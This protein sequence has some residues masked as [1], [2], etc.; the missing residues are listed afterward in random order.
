MGSVNTRLKKLNIENFE[1][2]SK[3][4]K[5]VAVDIETTGLDVS[6]DNIIE[7]SALKFENGEMVSDFTS[8]INTD[9]NLSDFI[10]NLT[11][12]TNDMIKSAPCKE[13]VIPR[14]FEFIENSFIV[15]H[16]AEFDIPFI[17]NY[18]KMMRLNFDNIIIDTLDISRKLLKL[19]KN[20]LQAVAKFLNIQSIPNHRAKQDARV[21]AEIFLCVQNRIIK[22]IDND[23]KSKLEVRDDTSMA[24][25]CNNSAGAYN[26]FDDCHNPKGSEN[27]QLQIS[28]ESLQSDRGLSSMSGD[29]QEIN[30]DV[31]NQY[32]KRTEVSVSQLNR[33]IKRL[34]DKDTMLSL[35]WVKGEISNFKKQFSGHL[36]FSLKDEDSLIRAIMFKQSASKLDFQPENGMKVVVCCKVS[37]YERDGQY[38][39]YV[40]SMELQGTGALHIAFEQLKKKLL[41]EG[42]FDT[43]FKKM[44]PKM[45]R[46][47]G[48][49]TSPTGAAVRDIINVATRRFPL[50]R[51][52]LFPVAVQG[53]EAVGQIVDA[54][55]YFNLRKNVDVIILGRGGGSIEELWAFNEEA[56]A[57]AV[58]F[59]DIPVI[60]A[61]GHETDVTICDFVA[62]LRAP[63]PSAAAELCVPSARETIAYLKNAESRIIY[64]VSQKIK[65]KFSILERFEV[66]RPADV[67]S[68]FIQ[69]VDHL[70]HRLY[71]A[72]DKIM[73]RKVNY[74]EILRGRFSKFSAYNSI[75][76]MKQKND[77]ALRSICESMEKKML[78]LTA[79]F[80]VLAGKLDSLSPLSALK[81]G[82]SLATS[83]DGEV[84]NTIDGV[85]NGDNVNIRVSDGSLS[86][87]V[88]KVESKQ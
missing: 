75:S 33:Y 55:S 47:V 41:S 10:V 85:K 12:I 53:D 20:N 78:K 22:K 87:V 67:I 68:N 62:D 43:K 61:V 2:V 1:L 4:R 8:F 21:C 86:A 83:S 50:C 56:V 13:D 16:N 32:Q 34:L 72:M 49:I 45:P 59:C 42:L 23:S 46:V 6:K 57:R 14:F 35:I 52:L 19:K 69:R 88:T 82:Y 60:S 73:I 40:T 58:F 51:I 80:E 26:R 30:A 17:V 38:Q 25:S 3:V 79:S 66:K 71:E 44:I 36:Y 7:I 74:C 77:L 15:V 24:S 28:L 29:S 63:T 37:S 65:N 64:S 70:Y 76:S 11:G 27:N 9:I 54:L 48:V 84:L 81:R 39:L 5:F 31:D 18:F